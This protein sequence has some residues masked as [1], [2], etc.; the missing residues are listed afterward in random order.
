MNRTSRRLLLLVGAL[1]TLSFV[2]FVITQTSRLVELAG[3]LHPTLGTVTL[4][5]LLALYATLLT[6]IL[7][8]VLRLPPPLQP[9]ASE[10]S[11]EFEQH[12]TNLRQRLEGNPHLDGPLATRED[13]ARA[14]AALGKRADELNR[15]SA[16]QIFY[17]TSLSQNGAI[18]AVVVFAL[19]VRLVWRIGRVYYQ[20]PTLRDLA[21]LYSNVAATA[22]VAAGIEDLD[23]TE[24]APTLASTSGGTLEG[25]PFLA[26]TSR[27]VANS[28]LSGTSNCYL[29]LRAGILTRDYCGMLV[30]E[31]R[32]TLRK[33]AF[34]EAGKLLAIVAAEGSA[35]VTRALGR[36]VKRKAS[37]AMSRLKP[38]AAETPGG[39]SEPGDL[40]DPEAV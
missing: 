15:A 25:I 32:R 34:I 17:L 24:L 4:W 13:V 1:V 29:F 11:P 8:Q 39:S 19:L 35:A 10:D 38:G 37:Q 6:T 2:V 9:P 7:V 22:F 20:R 16:R 36:G 3:T 30:V 23:V 26:G 40:A 18:D 5:T 28:L 21:Y 14:L 33:S 27:V 31:E 12:L